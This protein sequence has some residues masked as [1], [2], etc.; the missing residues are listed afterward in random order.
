MKTDMSRTT[1]NGAIPEIFLEGL[2]VD[3]SILDAL[4]KRH[5]CSH[6]RTIYFRRMVMV[7]NGLL[8]RIDRRNGTQRKVSVIADAVHRVKDLQKNLNEYQQ[9]QRRK[10]FSRRRRHDREEEKWDLQSLKKGV[11]T[12]DAA[13]RSTFIAQELRELV[14][15]W[16]RT[17]PEMLSRIRHASKPLFTEVSRGFFLPF[18]TVGL[19]A[20][21]RIR[22]LLMEIGL[23]GLTKL[24]NLRGEIVQILQKGDQRQT[25]MIPTELSDNDYKQCMNLFL[26]NDDDNDRKRKS[27]T[28]N[29]SSAHN[30][31]VDR[32]AILRSLGLMEST[33]TKS[34]G[35][36]DGTPKR[37][38]HDFATAANMTLEKKQDGA[39]S[40]KP[41]TDDFYA[42]NS[43]DR[44]AKLSDHDKLDNDEGNTESAGEDGNEMGKPAGDSFDRNMALVDRFQK[45]KKK[46]KESLKKEK[47]AK[48]TECNS[49]ALPVE[50][51]GKNKKRKSKSKDSTKTKKKKKT[52][53]SKN[54]FFDQLFD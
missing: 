48:K 18:C 7:L 13:T 32:S 8:R 49:E 50:T 42:L 21:A 26:E 1:N 30:L 29:T 53:Q 54:D 35:E 28:Q 34:K 44:L 15:L 23:R 33:K 25:T 40:T 36:S 2:A 11:T 10:S 3:V 51:E 12:T 6:G 19:S 17:I 27:L 39:F 37:D 24:Q 52:K 4:L 16:T 41:H 5:R 47:S 38:S 46:A 14:N 45:R 9:E 22:S 20:L 31:M 43:S